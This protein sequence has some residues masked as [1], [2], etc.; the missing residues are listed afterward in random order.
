MTFD[1]TAPWVQIV[2][3]LVYQ[4]TSGDVK[5]DGI[6]SEWQEKGLRTDSEK[7]IF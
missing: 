3:S 4:S 6:C 2:C 1:Q 5:A 7:S